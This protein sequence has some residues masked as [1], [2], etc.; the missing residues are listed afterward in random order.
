MKAEVDRAIRK[1]PASSHTICAMIRAFAGSLNRGV[2]LVEFD[3]L[4]RQVNVIQQ[5]ALHLLDVRGHLV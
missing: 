1:A 3:V 4:G 2:G 5:E